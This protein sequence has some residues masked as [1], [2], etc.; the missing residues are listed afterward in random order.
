M[1]LSG[2][3][4]FIDDGLSDN[5]KFFKNI[6][7]WL[8]GDKQLY[9]VGLFLDPWFEFSAIHKL[10]TKMDLILNPSQL[11]DKDIICITY[12]SEWP[13]GLND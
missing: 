1:F 2:H 4:R 13:N 9:N 6:F 3:S 10:S 7:K 12:F 5:L 8:S 11:K